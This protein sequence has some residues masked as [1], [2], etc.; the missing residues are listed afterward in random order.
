[1][2]RR[3]SLREFQE[4]LVKRLAEAR[5]G[6]RR[7]LLGIE[8]G[9]ERWLVELTDTGEVLPVPP[10][11]HVPLTRSWFRGVAN[12]RGTLYGVVDFANFHDLPKLPTIGRARLLLIHPRH[13]VNSALLCSRTSGLHSPEEF[14]EIV[15]T[16][17]PRPWVAGRA[18]DFHGTEWQRLDVA[19]LIRNPVFLE[20]GTGSS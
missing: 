14:E 16:E 15:D 13:G 2:A 6:D 17:D 18:R 20:A 19:A 10:I 7:T 12:V 1:M 8:A 5:T 9:E 4:N 11:S 3:I